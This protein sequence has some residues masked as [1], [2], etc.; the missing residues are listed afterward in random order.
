MTSHCTQQMKTRVNTLRQCLFKN[1]EH[2]IK[3]CITV[4]GDYHALNDEVHRLTMESQDDAH[5]PET[6]GPI[7]V[8]TDQ[9]CATFKCMARCNRD[10][11]AN[12][13][14]KQFGSEM[15]ALVQ[16][17][18][19]AQ[20]RDL[21]RLN[22]VHVMAQNTP[23]Q[24]NYMYEPGVVFN[25]TKDREMLQIMMHPEHNMHKQLADIVNKQAQPKSQ[26]LQTQQRQP[27]PSVA[28]AIN[29]VVAK[30][31]LRILMKQLELMQRQEALLEKENAKLDLEMSLLARKQAMQQ[32]DPS[33]MYP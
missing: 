16:V 9:A 22:I 7:L 33:Q 3:Q 25:V 6:L 12:S 32:S 1:G 10:S 27:Q 19:D 14:G 20:R 15:Q 26:A 8:K 21:E 5:N 11:L 30:S 24:C 17:V 23:P 28:S 31:Q 2:V 18:L 29:E 4:C 13:C